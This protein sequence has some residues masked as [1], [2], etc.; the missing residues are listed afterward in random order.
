MIKYHLFLITSIILTVVVQALLKSNSVKHSGNLFEAIYDS[1]L[2][3][4]L[5]LYATAMVFWYISSS[6]LQFTFMIPM[7]IL[8][9][10]FGGIIGYYFFE[11]SFSVQ[12]I[13]AYVL[14]IFGILMLVFNNN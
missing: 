6:K 7:Q 3:V 5:F 14:I 4:A 12:K 8:T 9:V 13:L 11:E 1:R 2:Y 10:V